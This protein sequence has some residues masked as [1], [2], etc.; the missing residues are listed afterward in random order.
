MS[1][2]YDVGD[3]NEQ[4]PNSLYNRIVDLNTKFNSKNEYLCAA[5]MSIIQSSGAGKTRLA[6]ETIKLF[7]GLFFEF[8]QGENG[9]PYPN[10]ELSSLVVYLSTPM[11]AIHQ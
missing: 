3:L 11:I 10:K 8:R 9:Y 4:N 2:F 5:Y 7:P 6:W 1:S